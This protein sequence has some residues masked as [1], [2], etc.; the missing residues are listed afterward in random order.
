MFWVPQTGS[1][2][3]GVSILSYG[4]GVQFGVI[5]DTDSNV[6]VAVV[7]IGNA[8]AIA[9]S[10]THSCALRSDETVV[11]WGSGGYGQLGDGTSTDSNVPVQVLGF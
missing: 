2:G 1:V 7:G 10:T 11:C 8:T 3:L 4:G 6:P 5:T 9:A